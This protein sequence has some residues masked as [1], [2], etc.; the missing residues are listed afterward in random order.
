MNDIEYLVSKYFTKNNTFSEETSSHWKKYGEK[1][2]IKLV[3]TNQGLKWRFRKREKGGVNSLTEL[4][5][6]VKA[7][8]I[9][10][11]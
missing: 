2:S 4:E 9:L 11:S 8:E 3:Y 7:L 1:Q 6:K 5:I 10:K